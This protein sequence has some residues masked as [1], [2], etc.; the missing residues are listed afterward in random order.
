MKKSY[1]WIALVWSLSFVCYLPMLLEKSGVG[2]PEVF[3]AA[4]YLFVAVPLIVSVIFAAVSG[5]FIKWLRGMFAIKITK[6]PVI[7]CVAAGTLG[8]TFSLIY[9]F[10]EGNPNLFYDNYPTA[11]SVVTGSIYLFFTAMLEEI[12][13]RGYLLNTLSNNGK[14]HIALL[15]TGISWSVWHIPMWT[16]RNSL[17]LGE[18]ALYFVW[19]F[20][21]SFVIGNL[22]I[23]Y[24]SVIPA[25]LLHM[26]FNTCF[27]APV[28]YNIVLI[29]FVIIV[30]L[31]IKKKRHQNNS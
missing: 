15:C 21:I 8:L 25:A 4:K 27:I 19:T 17:E 28:Q 12:A 3:I 2:V 13:W 26:L 1:L 23:T 5:E 18:T 7:Y 11:I 16:I 14:T 29:G 6:N 22:F 20:L 9:S 24:K 10:V 31:I 30:L